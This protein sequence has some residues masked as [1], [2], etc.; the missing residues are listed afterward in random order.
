MSIQ[1]ADCTTKFLS[2]KVLNITHKIE[3]PKKDKVRA[4]IKSLFY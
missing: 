1:T 2:A 3:K 4:L